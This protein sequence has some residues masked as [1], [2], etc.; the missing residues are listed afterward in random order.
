MDKYL[1][2][3]FSDSSRESIKSFIRSAQIS[4]NGKMILKPSAVLKNGDLISGTVNDQI[5]KVKL[6]PENIK[7]DI[8]FENNDVVVI[9]KPAGMVVHPGDANEA[10]TLAN[11]LIYHYPKIVYAI[12]DRGEDRLKNLRPGIVHRLD[13]DTSGV[14]I[15]AKH[16]K[17]YEYLVE[18]FK[19]RNIIKKY[20]AVCLGFLKNDSG[21]IESVIGRKPSNRKMMGEVGD[22]AGKK[23][24]TVYKVLQ[25]YNHRDTQFSLLEFEIKTGRT[26]QIRVHAKESGFPILGDKVYFIKESKATSHKLNVDRQLLHSHSLSLALPDE[27]MASIFKAPLAKDMAMIINLISGN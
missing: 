17:S 20:L 6:M 8:L 3:L 15:V 22:G 23:A 7:L 19:K 9:N 14:M 21:T 5:D 16:K 24:I 27:S 4:V 12:A 1:A 10:G 13:K 2:G 25:S 11:A 26:H 18:Q